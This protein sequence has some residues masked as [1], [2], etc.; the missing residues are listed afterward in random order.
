MFI[1][2]WDSP[3]TILRSKPCMPRCF[4]NVA[5]TCEFQCSS[6]VSAM[7]T[8][9]GKTAW[10]FF[11]LSLPSLEF[12]RTCNM[13]LL[14]MKLFWGVAPKIDLGWGVLQAHPLTYPVMAAPRLARD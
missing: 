1:G 13:H 11:G 14:R 5:E 8:A 2:F 12:A 9:K 6:K 3:P 4:D 10:A 7:Q